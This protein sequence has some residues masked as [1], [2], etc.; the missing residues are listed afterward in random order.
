MGRKVTD[1]ME[2]LKGTA[3]DQLT[4]GKLEE[5]KGTESEPQVAEKVVS[6]STEIGKLR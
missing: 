5:W 4:V 2:R 3:G 6:S 1:Q